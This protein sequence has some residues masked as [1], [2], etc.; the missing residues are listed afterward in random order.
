MK[1][2]LLLLL[3]GL[4]F[5]GCSEKSIFNE[6]EAKKEFSLLK[7][8]ASNIQ[9]A[10]VVNFS[11]M[12]D[13][14]RGGHI[15]IN[16][17][18]TTVEGKNVRITGTLEIPANAFEGVKNIVISLDDEYAVIDFSPSP[19]QFNLP[20]KLDLQYKGIN[21]NGIDKDNTN[22]FYISDDG[23]KIELIKVQSNVFDQTEGTIGIIKAELNHFSRF[24][25]VI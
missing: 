20:L 12:I 25:W 9:L 18:Y 2:V 23:N 10:K 8:P 11:G 24:G 15:S 7:I 1:R 21:L 14:S 13:G 5:S 22:F 4:F 16:H 19:C 6:P 17:S 3:V